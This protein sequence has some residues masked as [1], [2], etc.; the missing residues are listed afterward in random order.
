MRRA[1]NWIR[2]IIEKIVVLTNDDPLK[3]ALGRT[4]DAEIDAA[5]ARRGLSRADLFKPGTT[6]AAHRPRIAGMILMH[7]LSADNLTED[8]WP[9]LKEADHRCAFCPQTGRCG[10]WLRWGRANDAPRIFCPNALTFAKLAQRQEES[11]RL[12]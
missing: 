8:N 7:G 3:R 5:L 11:R 10:R 4:P 2:D 12:R 6:Q 9:V 1:W